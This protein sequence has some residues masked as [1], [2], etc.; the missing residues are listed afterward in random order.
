MVPNEHALGSLVSQ[1]TY[2]RTEFAPSLPSIDAFLRTWYVEGELP[3]LLP[4]C[5]LM[6]YSGQSRNGPCMPASL[7]PSERNLFQSWCW[8]S[9]RWTM[10]WVKGCP[11]HFPVSREEIVCA[12]TEAH[13]MPYPCS[14]GRADK[15][16]G[17]SSS[18]PLA[19]TL[20]STAWPNTMAFL[21]Q[22][23][24]ATLPSET[25]NKQAWVLT[26][27]VCMK[28][29][30]QLDDKSKDQCDQLQSLNTGSWSGMVHLGSFI[31]GHKALMQLTHCSCEAPKDTVHKVSWNATGQTSTATR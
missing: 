10:P 15:T 4:A 27:E 14:M 7:T 31:C 20:C 30:V 17:L 25:K 24:Q 21:T 8:K 5:V 11:F 16:I 1:L 29:K 26:L 22:G 6:P 12:K 18:F 9:F 28:I 3:L 2:L 13:W 19:D 23:P